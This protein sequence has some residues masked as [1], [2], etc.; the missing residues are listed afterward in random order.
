MSLTTIRGKFGGIPRFED[1]RYYKKHGG[2]LALT[3]PSRPDPRNRAVWGLGMCPLL[4]LIGQFL[5]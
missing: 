1:G 3:P 2:F 4:T 5:A